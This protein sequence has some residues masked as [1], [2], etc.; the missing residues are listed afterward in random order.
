MTAF[1]L[2]SETKLARPADLFRLCRP[3][4]ANARHC[5]EAWGME[6]PTIDVIDREDKLP[7]GMHPIVLVS[8]DSGDPGALAVHYHDPFRNGPAAVVYV[9]RASG[10]NHGDSSVC[11]SVGHEVLEALVNPRLNVWRQYV[12]TR[13]G[14]QAAGEVADPVQDTYEVSAWGTRWKVPNFVTP[15]WFDAAN[16]DATLAERVLAGRGFDHAK[17]LERPGQVGPEGYVVLRQRGDNGRW[18]SWFEGPTGERFG[19]APAKTP[20]QVHAARFDS[21]RSSMITRGAA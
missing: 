12:G 2:I 17:R 15:A 10:W 6:P 14:V 5:A 1:A 19:G 7:D 16:E 11:E 20:R 8:D 3:L 18:V 21:R 13:H 9:D 4:E